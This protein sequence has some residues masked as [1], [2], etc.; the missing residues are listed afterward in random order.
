M[1]RKIDTNEALDHIEGY[2]KNIADCA[3][4]LHYKLE[5]KLDCISYAIDQLDDLRRKMF[6]LDN[7]SDKDA[8]DW[9]Y[10]I[11][12]IIENFGEV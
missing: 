10:K 3:Q 8:R 9:S 1:Y 4:A 7:V 5:E 6:I 2:C 11:Q 12:E